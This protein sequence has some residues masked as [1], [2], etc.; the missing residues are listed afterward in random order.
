MSQ[1]KIDAYNEEY[2]DEQ[3]EVG[4]IIIDEDYSFFAQTSIDQLKQLYSTP[5]FDPNSHLYCFKDDAM[6][7]FLTGKILDQPIEGKKVAFMR[8]P[9]VLKEHKK[10]R[11]LLYQRFETYMKEQEVEI[12][13]AQASEAWGDTLEQ[14]EKFGFDH[15]TEDAYLY[16]LDLKK[17]QIDKLPNID[18]TEV[19]PFDF[20]RDLD[21]AIEFLKREY[22]IPAE[23]A[24]E[25]FEE[26]NKMGNEVIHVVIRNKAQLLAR[27]VAY[28]VNEE[29]KEAN[30]ASILAKEEKVRQQILLKI[31][32]EAKSKGWK[33]L[34]LVIQ[35]E[36]KDSIPYIQELGYEKQVTLSLYQKSIE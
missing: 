31:I 9:F 30:Q 34:N 7:G 20:K 33:K 35:Q 13:Q 32:K 17:T 21:D 15:V 6:V 19:I 25:N 36:N 3:V 22:E 12:I 27:G 16:S 8:F 24:I 5:D 4:N 1:Y 28:I 23:M 10:A 18:T 29:K 11:A 2:I 26:I 14:V